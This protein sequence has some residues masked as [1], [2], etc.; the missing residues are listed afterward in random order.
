MCVLVHPSSGVLTHAISG[1][2]RM[3][4]HPSA[5]FISCLFF[6]NS[7]HICVS[8]VYSITMKQRYKT[9]QLQ[10][11]GVTIPFTSKFAY[12]VFGYRPDQTGIDVQTRTSKK[13]LRGFP[14]VSV[15]APRGSVCFSLR[16]RGR[17]AL[18]VRVCT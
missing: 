5:F 15:A 9:R 10:I 17:P 2:F 12:V 18:E 3:R 8:I 13:N 7:A 11:C 4:R 14:S 6:W 16:A 1:V